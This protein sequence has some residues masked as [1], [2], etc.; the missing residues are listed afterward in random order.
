MNVDRELVDRVI[1]RVINSALAA[2]VICMTAACGSDL[3]YAPAPAVPQR[4]QDR[5]KTEVAAIDR[6]VDHSCGESEVCR[7]DFDSMA[8]LA[9]DIRSAMDSHA[10]RGR[11]T[12]VRKTVSSIVDG[13]AKYT[14][15]KCQNGFKPA[16]R[17][18][19]HDTGC[20]TM[21]AGLRSDWNELKERLRVAELG[22]AST[23]K[24]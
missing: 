17:G 8:K 18:S 6:V 21:M 2:L 23:H 9:G 12:E 10:D 11:Y 24:P 22:V 19:I 14:I 7:V 1:R 16:M 20:T 4:L 3:A 5:F 15:E 13:V